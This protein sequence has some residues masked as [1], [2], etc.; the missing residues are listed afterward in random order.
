MQNRLIMKQFSGAYDRWIL[1]KTIYQ[2]H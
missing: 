1:H 2:F